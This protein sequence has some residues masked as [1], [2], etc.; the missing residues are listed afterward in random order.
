MIYKTE[1]LRVSEVLS[2]CKRERVLI[3]SLMS[4]GA[5]APVLRARIGVRLDFYI[6]PSCGPP[7][8]E[9]TIPN[10]HLRS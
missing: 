10:S 8:Q 1:S 2:G 9:R 5:A 7:P 3:W 6:H 4:L